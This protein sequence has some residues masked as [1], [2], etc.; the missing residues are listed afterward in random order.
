MLQLKGPLV[1]EWKAL[2]Y[3]G[4]VAFRLKSGRG[5]HEV[6]G[7]AT[8]QKNI[9]LHINENFTIR[10]EKLCHNLAYGGRERLS[11]S[12]AKRTPSNSIEEDCL[13]S[14]IELVRTSYYHTTCAK[15]DAS[16]VEQIVCDPLC[17]NALD[18]SNN[19]GLILTRRGRGRRPR[20]WDISGICALNRRRH[21]VILSRNI[22]RDIWWARRRIQP[23][24]ERWKVWSRRRQPRQPLL[25]SPLF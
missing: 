17:V 6:E 21:R 4:E 22:P 5:A 20:K 2:V 10:L 12:M 23:G 25:G 18:R 24:P 13:S 19:V 14:G 3:F 11:G 15:T 9:G 8:L 7:K 1:Q 16:I